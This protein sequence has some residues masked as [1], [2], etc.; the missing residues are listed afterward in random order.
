VNQKMS[1][2]QAAIVGTLLGEP[3]KPPDRTGTFDVPSYDDIA[4]LNQLFK[5]FANTAVANGG[6]TMIGVYNIAG[7]LYVNGQPLNP[8]DAYSIVDRTSGLLVP[9]S[10]VLSQTRYMCNFLADDALTMPTDVAGIP[11][12]AKISIVQTGKGRVTIQGLQVVGTTQTSKQYQTIEIMYHNSVWW[13]L[14]GGGGTGASEGA[15]DKP[16]AVWNGDYSAIT[17]QPIS[18]SAGPT[19]GY[20]SI[21]TPSQD[22]TR[23]LDGTTLFVDLVTAGIE[24]EFQVWGVNAAGQ[25]EF[26]DP[27]RHTWT[28]VAAPVLTAS[29]G[30]AQI[31]AQWTQIAGV[32]GYRLGYKKTVDAD[33]TYES[34]NVDAFGDIISGLAEV[35]YQVR[36][37]ALD[38]PVASAWSNV[39]TATPGPGVTSTPT[40]A[41][42]AK[43]VFTI[44]NYNSKLLYSVDASAG[45][46]TVSGDKLTLSA[47][48]VQFL[49]KAQFAPGAPVSSVAGELRQY[50]THS[51]NQ[52]YA[53]GTVQ[54]NCVTKQYCHCGTDAPCDSTSFDQC[55]CGQTTMCWYGSYQECSECTKYCDNYVQV[56]D[57]TPVGFV[58]EYGEWSKA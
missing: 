51:E 2:E 13:C 11:D 7:S 14:A 25:G 24:C 5:R 21:V 26:S 28:G 3:Y 20:G 34:E 46:G 16:V 37:Q 33:W 9:K 35:E 39:V 31:T 56:K 23:R 29:S 48:N 30:P 40:I 18:G 10:D 52:P 22:V 27:L 45:T 55:G 41:H 43:G 19:L 1:A 36:V 53:C 58:D 6:D 50:T 42:S 15:P 57:G 49:L 47:G 17:W 12:G 32:T 44:Q 8:S 54:C 38:V 4:D